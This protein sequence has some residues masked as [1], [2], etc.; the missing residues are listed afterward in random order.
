MTVDQTPAQT[1]VQG[2]EGH[3]DGLTAPREGGSTAEQENGSQT[4]DPNKSLVEANRRYVGERDAAREALSAAEARI[5]AM[6]RREINRLAGEHLSV[7][8]DLFI[9]GNEVSDYLTESGDVDADKVAADVAA[10]LAERPGLRKATPGYDPSQGLG[11]LG[12]RRPEPTMADL[13]KPN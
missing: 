3:A 8:E 13:F 10:V 5:E 11:G 9:S 12:P 1:P 6:N 7:G 4:P 2:P